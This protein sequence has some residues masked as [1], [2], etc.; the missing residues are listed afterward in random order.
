MQQ[1]NRHTIRCMRTLSTVCWRVQ[2]PATNDGFQ[3][4]PSTNNGDGDD[5]DNDGDSGERRT[6]TTTTQQRTQQRNDAT[7]TQQRLRESFHIFNYCTHEF[8]QL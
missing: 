7:T 1:K 2:V 4:L 8:H 3:R 6:A 5:D